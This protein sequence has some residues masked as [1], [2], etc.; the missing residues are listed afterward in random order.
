M[1]DAAT[2]DPLFAGLN[3]KSITAIPATVEKQRF[4]SSPAPMAANPGKWIEMPRLP[5]ATGE[6]AVI[7]CQ[8]NIHVIAGYARHRVDGNFHQ[9][10]DPLQSCCRR[11]DR[12]EGLHLRR[13]RRAEPLPAFQVLRL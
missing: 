6:H 1:T 8:G 11:F 9:V 5:I 12:L 2:N 4:I 10:S 7:E 13:L 3:D